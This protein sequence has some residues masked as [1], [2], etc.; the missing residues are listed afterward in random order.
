MAPTL[1]LI[2][3]VTFWLVEFCTEAAKDCDWPSYSEELEGVIE[4]G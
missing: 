4:T 1:G 3:H 2:D